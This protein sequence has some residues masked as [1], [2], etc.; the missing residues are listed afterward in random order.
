[1]Q[2]GGGHE[3]IG[4]DAEDAVGLAV[5]EEVDT[6]QPHAPRQDTC[7]CCACCQ[8]MGFGVVLA[9]LPA[10]GLILLVPA[11]M[12]AWGWGITVATLDILIGVAGWV[13][14][15]RTRKSVHSVLSEAKAGPGSLLALRGSLFTLADILCFYSLLLVVVQLLPASRNP[16]WPGLGPDGFPTRCLAGARNCV[17]VG[18]GA[19][20]SYAAEGLSPMQIKGTRA[21]VCRPAV[22]QGTPSQRAPAPSCLTAPRLCW[23]RWLREA[24]RRV[25]R[26]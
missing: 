3:T 10:L 8:T 20:D 14:V 7:G 16:S 17:R 13:L 24:T 25:R 23:R 21:Q 18:D 11:S 5:G 19:A 26:Q 15:K 6:D 1:M 22:P 9:A 12:S 2:A 4:G